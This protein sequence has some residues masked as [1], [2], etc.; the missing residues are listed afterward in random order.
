MNQSY[1]RTYLW[2]KWQ[3]K[4]TSLN[5]SIEIIS[6]IGRLS[7]GYTPCPRI[8]DVC[9]ERP[10]TFKCTNEIYEKIGH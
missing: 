9:I 1:Y 7:V 10:Y 5:H 4:S 6:T 8:P 2:V 3:S